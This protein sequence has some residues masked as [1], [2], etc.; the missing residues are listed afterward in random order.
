MS[1]F[2][3]EI[4]SSLL[5]LSDDYAIVV[6]NRS[7]A[8]QA[9]QVAKELGLDITIKAADDGQWIIR[10][11]EKSSITMF[12]LN[13]D[14]SKGLYTTRLKHWELKV[15][16]VGASGV[17]RTQLSYYSQGHQDIPDS[18]IV[19]VEEYN[20][21]FKPRYVLEP[22]DLLNDKIVSLGLQP[23]RFMVGEDYNP[24]PP[25]E[26]EKRFDFLRKRSKSDETK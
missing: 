5:N 7:E 11:K 8:T 9:R 12:K 10:P 3:S 16:P 26:A 4:R 15:T 19:F 23:T 13:G 21:L 22:Y 18:W 25:E 17:P 2:R 20:M 24:L 6:R 1:S 14:T